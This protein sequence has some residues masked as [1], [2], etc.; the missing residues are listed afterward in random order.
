MATSI[1]SIGQSALAAAQVG[2]SVTGHNI[3]NAATPGYSRQE[4]IQSAALAQ[5][6]G[7]G[8]IG[9]GTIVSNIRRVYSDLLA[10]QLNTCLLY[11]SRCV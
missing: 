11:T 6:F 2:I 5:D 10:Q 9:Q 1:L 4:V 3:A 7:F 8:Y